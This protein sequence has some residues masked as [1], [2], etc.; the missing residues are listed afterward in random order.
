MTAT[1]L[2]D[3]DELAAM[4]EALTEAGA[5][6]DVALPAAVAAFKDG[7]W[8]AERAVSWVTLAKSEHPEL[9]KKQPTGDEA[10]VALRAAAA[11]A[12]R[13]YVRSPEPRSPVS[14][15]PAQPNSAACRGWAKS[16]GWC[17]LPARI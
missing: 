11:Q 13:R 6:L 15:N 8:S 3:K 1:L 4:K 9:W 17:S 10:A 12:P 16:C 7:E 2:P 14:T 5:N